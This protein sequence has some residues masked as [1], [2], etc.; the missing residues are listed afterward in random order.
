MNEKQNY[1]ILL[2]YKYTHINDPE[3]LV[4]A[5]KELGTRLGLKGRV[6]IAHEGING[7]VE[8]TIENTEI[9]KA[10]LEKV[11]ELMGIEY[12]E[13]EGTGHAFPK[14]IVRLRPEIVSS[15]LGEENFNP[16]DFTAQYITADEL[17]QWF[18]EEREFYIVDMRNDYEHRVGYF[19]NSILPE[20]RNFRD[21]KKILPSIEHL[22]GKTVVTVCT[23]GVRCEKASGFLLRNGFQ[24]VYQLKDGIVAY[25]EKYPNQ[26][27]L[28]KL[29]VF[30]GRITMGFNVD[31]PN[32][33]MVGK[34]QQCG[35]PS[36]EY[37]NC[38]YPECHQHIICCLGC[39][40]D[41]IAYCSEECARLA[42]QYLASL[43]VSN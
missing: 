38:A 21:L 15:H 20:M 27:Y 14:L 31:D 39:S 30:D 23:G 18:L 5:H 12:K 7:T 32:Y 42:P 40:P 37:V 10:E 28:G 22:K 11:P 8:G 9:Y 4:E 35:N 1:R 6:L 26:K 17:Q 29:Y 25:M 41:R 13:S 3:A 43:S 34:C 36:E 33:R 19:E 2:Y 24:D 16:A